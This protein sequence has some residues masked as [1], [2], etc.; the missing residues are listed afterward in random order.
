MYFPSLLSGAPRHAV[1]YRQTSFAI[2]H[3]CFISFQCYQ[4]KLFCNIEKCSLCL[5]KIGLRT[6]NTWCK[7]DNAHLKPKLQCP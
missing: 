5:L 2:Q 6:G 4:S 3:K 1:M 7:Y